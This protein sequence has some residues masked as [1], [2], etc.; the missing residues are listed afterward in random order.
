M[1][2]SITVHQK[3]RG[4]PATGRDP[5]ITARLPETTIAKV[6][7]WAAKNSAT[8]SDAI[9]RLVELGLGS[10]PPAKPPSKKSASKASALAAEQIDRLQHDKPASD[11]ERA[12]QKRRLLKGPSE[13]RE[14]RKDLSKAKGRR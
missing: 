2:K 9:R 6:D 4:R 13:F 5:A 14:I 8:R 11:D 1:T 10:A 12:R 7:Q 3:K